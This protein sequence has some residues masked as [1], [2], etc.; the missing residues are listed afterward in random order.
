MAKSS[1][2]EKEFGV[3]SCLDKDSQYNQRLIAQRAGISLGLTN[4]I[5]QR[6][7]KKGYVKF[8]QLTPKKIQYMLTP[9]GMTAKVKRSYDFTRHTIATMR[10]MK[11]RIQ[12]TIL[13]SYEDGSRRFLIQGK[14]ELADLVEIA[15]RDLA[16]EG[17]SFAPATP[18]AKKDNSHTLILADENMDIT[19]LNKRTEINKQIINVLK[20][21]AG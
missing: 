10:D 11:Q 21:L 1:I 14:G 4:L 16:L 6:L 2:S 8:K 5:I 7:V 9:K 13:K 19:S 18:E 17:V 12:E 3:I 20:I 15:I